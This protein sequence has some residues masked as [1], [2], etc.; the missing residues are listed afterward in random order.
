MKYFK[1]DLISLVCVHN[2]FLI[3]HTSSSSPSSSLFSKCNNVFIINL[4]EFFI[5][6]FLPGNR[7]STQIKWSFYFL[8]SRHLIKTVLLGKLKLCFSTILTLPLNSG[9]RCRQIRA[10]TLLPVL[11]FARFRSF[12]L[13]IR[14]P[15]LPFVPFALATLGKAT[16]SRIFLLV[17]VYNRFFHHFFV[18]LF[19]TVT[20]RPWFSLHGVYTFRNQGTFHAFV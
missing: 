8:V 20:V 10:Q 19:L 6:W 5:D 9:H 14:I 15:F 13:L 18:K 11:V 16:L 17:V 7:S 3:T 1:N 12:A 4:L 2:M